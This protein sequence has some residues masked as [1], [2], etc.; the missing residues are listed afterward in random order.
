MQAAAEAS[1]TLRFK[2]S[3]PVSGRRG[4]G[5]SAP[6]FRFGGEVAADGHA[7]QGVFVGAEPDR[8]VVVNVV[9]GGVVGAG[10]VV[11]PLR[12]GGESVFLRGRA[13][14]RECLLV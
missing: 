1:R 2:D 7:E 8:A 10:G 6:L 13:D 3:P 11:E 4:R 9:E 12:G 14:D 5:G